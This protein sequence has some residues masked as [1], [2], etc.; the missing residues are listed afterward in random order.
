MKDVKGLFII[1]VCTLMILGSHLTCF[2]RATRNSLRCPG[3]T[4]LIY[5]G[6]TQ[7]EVLD[8]CGEPT[9]VEKPTHVPGSNYRDPVEL[10]H[11]QYRIFLGQGNRTSEEW[12]YNFGPTKFM[13]Y[14]SFQSGEVV[15]IETGGYGY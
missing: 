4:G 2:A 6:D 15:R 3:S 12:T 10:G 9:S 13:T 8:Q 1:L 7:T 11:E 14:L 5:I